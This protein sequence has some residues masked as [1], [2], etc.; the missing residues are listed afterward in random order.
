MNLALYPSRVRSSEVLEG[1]ATPSQLLCCGGTNDDFL[2]MGK[3]FKN[4]ALTLRIMCDARAYP[5]IRIPREH[6][7]QLGG[8]LALVRDGGSDRS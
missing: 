6:L 1:I 7:A 5:C 8:E 3:R 2:I 4:L